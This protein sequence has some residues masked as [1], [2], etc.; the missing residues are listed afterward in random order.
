M[1]DDQERP[2]RM[3]IVYAGDQGGFY[4][5]MVP[6]V[7]SDERLEAALHELGVDAQAVFELGGWKTTEDDV[8]VARVPAP[9]LSPP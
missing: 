7:L 5:A 6:A 3:M 8:A 1:N 9:G 4:V 2:I